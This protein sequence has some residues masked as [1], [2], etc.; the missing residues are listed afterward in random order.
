MADGVDVMPDVIT[1]ERPQV[2]IECNARE[3][4]FS[5][6]ATGRQAR[7]ECDLFARNIF[8]TNGP[9]PPE[10]SGSQSSALDAAST[11]ALLAAEHAVSDNLKRQ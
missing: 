6:T 3:P 11:R 8:R 9:D 10:R 4:P 1:S 2:D 5:K 7:A